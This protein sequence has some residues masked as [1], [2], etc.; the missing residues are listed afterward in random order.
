MKVK[1]QFPDELRKSSGLRIRAGSE[2]RFIGIWH[3]VVK[4]QVFVRSW[5]VKESGWY[6]TLLQKPRGAIQLKKQEIAVTAKRATNKALR[7]A[8]DRAY[9]EK[10]NSPGAK[11][12]AR[13]LCS[14]KSRATTMELL[15]GGW[16]T[17]RIKK[18]RDS[19]LRSE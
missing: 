9:L 5:T 2:H 11:K 3:V 6:R 12:Y 15:P 18:K 7:D 8:V 10:Y 14:A 1:R 19:S 4:E 17:V 16:S 13:D